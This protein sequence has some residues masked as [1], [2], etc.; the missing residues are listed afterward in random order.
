MTFTAAGFDCIRD[1]FCDA[2]RTGLQPVATTARR[3]LKM[4]GAP[5]HLKV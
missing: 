5:R 3:V 1:E 2:G 4:S